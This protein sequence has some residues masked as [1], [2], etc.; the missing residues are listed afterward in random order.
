MLV[1]WRVNNGIL[2]ISTGAGFLNHPTV[3]IGFIMAPHDKLPSFGSGVAP[4]I[5]SLRWKL[6][7]ILI[8]T[9]EN[10]HEPFQVQIIC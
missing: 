9:W 6:L 10:I 4:S 2:Y 5:L 7:T 1:P 3:C 8:F